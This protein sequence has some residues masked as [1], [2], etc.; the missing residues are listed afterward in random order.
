M[1]LIRPGQLFLRGDALKPHFPHEPRDAFPVDLVALSLEPDRH[2]GNAPRR[3]L[4]VP[5]VNEFHEM[6]VEVGDRNRPIVEARPGKAH[7]L[8]LP[9]NGDRLVVH[10]DEPPFLLE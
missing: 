2:P 7:K 3:V 4:G 9:G 10:V 6:E 1:L 5:P 8:A